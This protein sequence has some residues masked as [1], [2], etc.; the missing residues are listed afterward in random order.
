M[1]IV[2]TVSTLSLANAIQATT[3]SC[4]RRR[5]MNANLIRAS[6]VDIVKISLAVINAVASLEHRVAIA[7]I[8]SMNVL[9]IHA[10]MAPLVSTGS[11]AIL[12]IAF[13]DSPANIAKQTS[14]SVPAI[15]VLTEANARTWS[16]DSNAIVPVVILTP[17]A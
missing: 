15:H 3:D 12:A 16:T 6:L 5:S 2:L 8:T 10:V 4:V 13:Q 7:N 17:A 9:A 1:A 14:T 11:I